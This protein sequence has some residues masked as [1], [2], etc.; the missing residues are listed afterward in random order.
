MGCHA[1]TYEDKC[2]AFFLWSSVD[3]STES[4][5]RLFE[6]LALAKHVSFGILFGFGLH[7]ILRSEPLLSNWGKL[8]HS[9]QEGFPQRKNIVNQSGN[10]L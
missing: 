8:K 2:V 4:L 5:G 1:I 10:Q 3:R 9:P 6:T 7:Y